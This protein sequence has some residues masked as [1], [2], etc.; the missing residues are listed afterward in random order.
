[1]Q[2][3]GQLDITSFVTTS[4]GTLNYGEWVPGFREFSDIIIEIFK[5]VGGP[6][7]LC[8]DSMVDDIADVPRLNGVP[9]WPSQYDTPTLIKVFGSKEAIKAN[10]AQYIVQ[11]NSPYPI[12]YNGT[13]VNSIPCNRAVKNELEQIFKEVL[14][15]YGLE[16]IKKLKLNV[17]GTK[18]S[19]YRPGDTGSMHN[20]GIAFDWD[21]GHNPMDWDS[22]SPPSK[23]KFGALPGYPG[24]S[25][26]W[27]PFWH[28][29]ENHGAQSLGRYNN[30]DWMHVQFATWPDYHDANRA[31]RKQDAL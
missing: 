16:N 17:M 30:D 14:A 12:L 7:V 22:A 10:Q 9:Q 29:W 8:A 5:S 6:N 3:N 4:H 2:A 19:A 26:A 27:R 28:I 1:M 13:W 31:G 25:K 24:A 18:N 20:Y 15:H 21:P 11:A 23:I